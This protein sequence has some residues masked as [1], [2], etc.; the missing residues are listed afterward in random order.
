MELHPPAAAAA[1]M[2]D[3]PCPFAS[4]R[5]ESYEKSIKV[6]GRSQNSWQNLTRFE[7]ALKH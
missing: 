2:V 7:T 3:S 5:F 6:L 4:Y 1:T